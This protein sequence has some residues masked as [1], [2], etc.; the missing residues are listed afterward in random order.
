MPRIAVLKS[1]MRQPVGESLDAVSAALTG[2]AL[3]PRQSYADQIQARLRD[4][5]LAGKLTPGMALSEAT[6]ALAMGV[7][8]QPVREAL[9]L[10]AQEHLVD[11]FPQ[12]GTVVA[13]VRVSLIH[14]GRF[15][16]RAL[17]AANLAELVRTIT[18]AQVAEIK[19]LL[20]AQRAAVVA[21]LPGEFF[22]LDET[23]HARFFDFT[24]RQRVWAMVASVKVHLDRVRF[25]LLERVRKHAARAL[26][27]HQALVTRLAAHDAPGVAMLI[28]KHVD[29]VAE[30]LELL[31]KFTPAD[32][33]VD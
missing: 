22:R 14:E 29:S 32:Y 20:V 9:R 16:R 15:I 4:A 24:G 7:S 23:M 2:A 33:F 8:R 13:P 21:G 18:P 17:E 10:L 19:A 5:V 11:V 26:R 27:E 6:V 3:D 1:P 28:N 12:V 31:R 25:L 30:D